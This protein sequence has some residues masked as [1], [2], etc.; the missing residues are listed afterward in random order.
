MLGKHASAAQ[1]DESAGTGKRK[2][3]LYAGKCIAARRH[4]QNP[5]KNSFRICAEGR[6]AE[7]SEIGQHLRK[8]GK[9]GDETADAQDCRD[10][11]KHDVSPIGDVRFQNGPTGSGSKK[12]T[13]AQSRQIDGGK[14][15]DEQDGARKSVTI[16][17]TADRADEKHRTGRTAKRGKSNDFIFLDGTR[18]DEFVQ[19]PCADRIARE[20]RQKYDAAA[21]ARYA[22]QCAH[23]TGEL[24]GEAGI[25]GRIDE[26]SREKEKGKG[27][28]QNRSHP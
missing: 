15:R 24:G 1:S 25:D 18:Q 16:E 8:T 21:C 10:G 12:Q 19:C 9:Y 17:H 3:R 13:G 11:G 4:L 7:Q 27:C 14:M 6:K 22:K 5:L 2:G 20:R 28:R 23:G 26:K